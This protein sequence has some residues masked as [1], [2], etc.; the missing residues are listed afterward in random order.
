VGD[1]EGEFTWANLRVSSHVQGTCE[2]TYQTTFNK[3]DLL[4]SSLN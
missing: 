3:A 1:L 4:W 2:D